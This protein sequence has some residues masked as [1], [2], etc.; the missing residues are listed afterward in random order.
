LN[1]DLIIQLYSKLKS[2]K[3]NFDLIE[4][5]KNYMKILSKK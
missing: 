1:L 2:E 4:A 3:E 5:S